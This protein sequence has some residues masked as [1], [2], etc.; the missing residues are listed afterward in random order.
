MAQRISQHAKRLQTISMVY[1]HKKKNLIKTIP[2]D[3]AE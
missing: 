3:K 2:K 1:P